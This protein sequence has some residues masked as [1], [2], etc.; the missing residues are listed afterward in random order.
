MRPRRIKRKGLAS[1]RIARQ[2][3]ASMV[4]HTIQ[5]F[6]MIPPAECSGHE[7]T[8]I[9]PPAARGGASGNGSEPGEA[10]GTEA[11]PD[12]VLFA[13]SLAMTYAFRTENRIA[14]PPP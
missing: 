3:T 4:N 5:R 2:I 10:S 8:P 6:F 7:V 14:S 9:L 12:R 13:P 11:Q 1:A